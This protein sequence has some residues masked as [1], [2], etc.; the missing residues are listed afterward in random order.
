MSNEEEMEELREQLSEFE[1][2]I[3]DNGQDIV[4]M[5]DE[6]RSDMMQ[7]IEKDL[8][9]LD[10]YET[11]S[12]VETSL[13][14]VVQEGRTVLRFYRNEIECDPSPRAIEVYAD[15]MESLGGL[16]ETIINAQQNADKLDIEREKVEQEKQE[17]AKGDTIIVGDTSEIIEM[18]NDTD[19][20]VID[21]EYEEID[22]EKPEKPPEPQESDDESDDKEGDDN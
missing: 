21:A 11:E 5:A 13:R 15:L 10:D 9:E 3:P 18:I 16:L 4:R 14:Q 6:E 17:G 22:E 20:E 1:E 7:N 2:D 12:F 19:Q 8:Q